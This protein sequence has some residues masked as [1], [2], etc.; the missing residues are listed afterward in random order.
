MGRPSWDEYFQGIVRAVS[1]RST[2][3]RKSVGAVIVVDRAVV[4]TGYNGAASGLPDCGE[5]GHMMDG[6]GSCVRVVHAEENAVAG[7]ARLGIPLDGAEAY[8]TCSPCWRCFR[9]L[10]QVGVRRIVY[11]EFYRDERIFD[12]SILLG[13]DLVHLTQ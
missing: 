10:A 6:N 8:V 13:I 2:C 11:A 7:A 4:A 12:S 9:L 5:A 1:A 3:D